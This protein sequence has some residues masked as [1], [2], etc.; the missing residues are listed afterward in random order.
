MNLADTEGAEADE[1]GTILPDP[2]GTQDG[3]R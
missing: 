3:T 2:S 1:T